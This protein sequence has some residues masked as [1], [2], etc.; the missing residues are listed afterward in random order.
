MTN[1]EAI[2]RLNLMIEPRQE[3]NNE[4]IKVA[5]RAIRENGTKIRCKDCKWYEP[6]MSGDHSA[7]TCGRGMKAVFA[8]DYCSLAERRRACQNGSVL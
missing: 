8:N 4:A 3:M 2:R 5:V 7:V 1:E 6:F